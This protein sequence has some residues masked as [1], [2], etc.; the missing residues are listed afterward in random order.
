MVVDDSPTVRKLVSVTLSAAGYEVAEANDADHAAKVLRESAVPQLFIL[1]VNM[2]G[3][4]GFELCKILQGNDETSKI[5]VMFLT[6]KPSG[7]VPSTR[8]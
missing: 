8:D 7:P 2:P 4:D 5:P 3:M 6:G 1:D